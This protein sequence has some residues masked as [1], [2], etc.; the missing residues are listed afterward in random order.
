M[1]ILGT[2]LIRSGYIGA[3]SRLIQFV[4]Y[5]MHYMVVFTDI[6]L[7]AK[8]LVEQMKLKNNL[9]YLLLRPA[10]L[11]G[12][13]DVAELEQSV[14]SLTEDGMSLCDLVEEVVEGIG[15]PTAHVDAFAACRVRKRI[16]A[17]V[18]LLVLQRPHEDD[19]AVFVVP[20]QERTP[21]ALIEDV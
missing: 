8:F 16:D 19:V 4:I 7:A 17:L 18:A 2:V 15:S 3:E 5:D 20:A 6:G 14:T 11:P 1:Y 13:R 12:V 9:T 10:S 21:H